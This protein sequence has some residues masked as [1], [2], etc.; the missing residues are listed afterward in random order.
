MKRVAGFTLVE[1]LVALSITALVGALAYGSLATV[2]SGVESNRTAT[3]RV[4]ELNRALRLIDRDLRQLVARPVRDEFGEME[5]ALRGAS[6]SLGGLSFTRA[7]WSNSQLR[8]RSTQQRVRY[9]VEENT[10]WRESYAVL[11]RAP[12][13]EVQ[14]VALL[15]NVQSMEL[16]FLEQLESLQLLDGGAGIDSSDWLDS[17]AMDRS[18]SDNTV[19]LPAALE[20][21]LFIADFGE[22]RRWY[23]IDPR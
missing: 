19:L 1:V 3:E 6:D 7:G 18:V 20:I 21:T 10:L 2:L 4:R 8:P 23:A 5:A 15:E 12:D 13:T 16:K 22:V 17:W 11:D 14:R 9:V